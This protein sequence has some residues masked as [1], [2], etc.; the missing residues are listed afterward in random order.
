MLSSLWIHLDLQFLCSQV[1]KIHWTGRFG[2]AWEIIELC[3][4][5]R[6]LCAF[7][8][9][10]FLLIYKDF[11]FHAKYFI[12]AH[13]SSTPW[14]TREMPHE[15]ECLSFHLSA[16]KALSEIKLCPLVC[17]KY[18]AISHIHYEER[19]LQMKALQKSLI[20]IGSPYPILELLNSSEYN[21][22]CW[23]EGEGEGN[24][25]SKSGDS[26]AILKLILWKDIT[27]YIKH[28]M[29]NRKASNI[30]VA[31]QRQMV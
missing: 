25:F 7:R 17:L 21:N 26:L 27:A 13:F 14:V 12:P 23:W 18:K 22:I 10:F 1:G 19:A 4:P 20:K 15:G 31:L 11:F 6:F 2:G 24:F 30:A 28:E 29:A 16:S 9:L 5:C 3:H 8:D